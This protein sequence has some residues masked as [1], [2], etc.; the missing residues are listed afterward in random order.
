MNTPWHY[1]FT[2]IIGVGS[3][4]QR[5]RWCFL[6]SRS[7]RPNST[8]RSRRPGRTSA[9]SSVS[10]LKGY[11]Q[12]YVQ[13]STLVLNLLKR[14][15][16]T[17]FSFF[18]IVKHVTACKLLDH[19]RKNKQ[20]IGKEPNEQDSSSHRIRRSSYKKSMAALTRMHTHSNMSLTCWLPWEP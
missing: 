8:L 2:S 17:L 20:K 12:A 10:G 18:H 19:Q 6:T 1:D 4:E 16:I 5:C 9:G 7:G 14:E 15:D 3:E 11:N 13:P